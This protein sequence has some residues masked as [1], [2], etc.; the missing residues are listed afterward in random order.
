MPRWFYGVIVMPEFLSFSARATLEEL[1][2]DVS[3]PLSEF[4]Q[5]YS[6]LASINRRLGGVRAIERFLPDKHGLD[7]LDVAA[8]GCDIGDTLAETRSCRV[9]SLDV[10]PMGLKRTRYT[11]PVVA[12]GMRLPFADNTFDAVIC[13]LSFH[14]LT[15]SQC[16]QV[17]REMWRTSRRSI[18]VNDLHRHPL[19]YV[20]IWILSRLFNKSVMVKHDGPV[21]VRRAFRPVELQ[22]I[23]RRAGVNARVH[24]SFPFR[25]VL[26]GEK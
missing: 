3:R 1:M 23:A 9:V 26:V 22:E 12:D 19:A 13:T 2:D 15:D 14:H 24:R 18:L 16:E 10:N 21:S 20:S 17:L 7:I 25:L 6:E 11:W 8:G 5:A 4:E